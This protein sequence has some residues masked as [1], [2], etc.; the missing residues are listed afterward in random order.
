M[1]EDDVDVRQD[2]KINAAVGGRGPALGTD[3]RP[4]QDGGRSSVVYS[5]YTTGVYCRPSCPSRT[6]NPNNVQLHDTLESAKAT[7]FRPCKRCNPDGPSIEDENAILV[8]KA[9]RIIAESEEE[10]SMEE[11]AA[12][13]GRSP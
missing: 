11:L 1:N 5:V 10:L 8:A 3:C 13:V 2:R 7:G 9:C 12:A 4:G 6:A